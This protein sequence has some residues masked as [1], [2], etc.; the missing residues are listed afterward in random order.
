MVLYS[1]K[2][3]SLISIEISRK[4]IDNHQSILKKTR[5]RK[6]KI[7]INDFE[8]NFV[9][10]ENILNM[11]TSLTQL[12][13][14]APS[15]N[16]MNFMEYINQKTTIMKI[17]NEYMEKNNNLIKN[18]KIRITA[19]NKLPEVI[20]HVKT[21]VKKIYHNFF[22]DDISVIRIICKRLLDNTEYDVNCIEKLKNANSLIEKTD[23]ITLFVI[24]YITNE[25]IYSR[26]VQNFINKKEYDVRMLSLPIR[27]YETKETGIM[28]L[29]ILD[30]ITQETGYFEKENLIFLLNDVFGIDKDTF[31]NI[32]M[33]IQEDVSN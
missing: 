6:R 2:L 8:S 15:K 19:D 22:I 26:N 1:P 20:N 25:Y 13:K 10:V 29:C 11:S 17:V 4:D 18:D 14:P 33:I 3:K 16:K 24:N 7:R 32:F 9:K 21:N 30:N 23:E 12:K 27:K 28:T 5:T 31:D